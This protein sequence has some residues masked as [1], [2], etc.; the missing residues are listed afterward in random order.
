MDRKLRISRSALPP[1]DEAHYDII[2]LHEDRIIPSGALPLDYENYG[3]KPS[4]YFADNNRFAALDLMRAIEENRLPASNGYDAITVLEM[5]YA[6][7]ESSL[8]RK[9]VELPLINRK[10]PLGV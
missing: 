7:Y 1:E 8:K 2:E 5:I 6:V 3:P 9:A 10:H 4:H